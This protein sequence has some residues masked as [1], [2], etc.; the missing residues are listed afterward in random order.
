MQL[1]TPIDIAFEN[2]SYTQ[3][4]NIKNILSSSSS[5]KSNISDKEWRQ[6]KDVLIEILEK[7]IVK[8]GIQ[9]NKVNIMQRFDNITIEHWNN[10]CNFDS[11]MELNKSMLSSISQYMSNDNITKNT[12]MEN[13]NENEIRERRKHDID[14]SYARKVKM[15]NEFNNKD[16]P[17][18]IDFTDKS[19]EPQTDVGTMLKLEISE[20]KRQDQMEV[21]Q[22]N[23]SNKI[24]INGESK[25]VKSQINTQPQIEHYVRWYIGDETSNG[26]NNIMKNLNHN[27]DYYYNLTKK[28]SLLKQIFIPKTTST[29]IKYKWNDNNDMIFIKPLYVTPDFTGKNIDDNNIQ[30]D[31]TI[32]SLFFREKQ[33]ESGDL[34]SGE[35]TLKTDIDNNNQENIVDFEIK[36]PIDKHIYSSSEL[37]IY[38][39]ICHYISN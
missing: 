37:N 23:E 3:Q 29:N 13:E 33:L 5:K 20:R 11:L 9:S 26:T 32:F 15:F 39:Q 4:D 35:L 7:T 18:P 28:H 12:F 10:R 6:N 21:P 34:Y 25:I 16:K 14:T 31:K 38:L 22:L 24:N 30:Q 8:K 1:G 2:P 19:D 36:T 27:I 17:K